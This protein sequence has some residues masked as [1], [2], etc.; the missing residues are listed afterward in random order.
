MVCDAHS[1]TLKSYQLQESDLL[2]LT[3]IASKS[4]ISNRSL[5]HTNTLNAIPVTTT[6]DL[7]AMEKMAR[8]S[9]MKKWY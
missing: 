4:N 1:D 7:S 9:F 5:T 8:N 3:V 2:K 6:S